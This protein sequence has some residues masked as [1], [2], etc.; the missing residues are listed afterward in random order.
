MPRNPLSPAQRRANIAAAED[1]ARQATETVLNAALNLL[2]EKLDLRNHRSQFSEPMT[3]VVEKTARK[4]LKARFKV[5]TRGRKRTYPLGFF[6]EQNVLDRGAQLAR[7]GI[8]AGKAAEII[9]AEL[10]AE[11][12]TAAAI[13]KQHGLKI[14]QGKVP[15]VSA[16][17]GH[18]ERSRR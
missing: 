13:I 17:K 16:I 3:K 5:E 2:N 15:T 4:V 14:E 10:K 7:E 11:Y 12:D 6:G 1:L 8:G 18:L 9:H